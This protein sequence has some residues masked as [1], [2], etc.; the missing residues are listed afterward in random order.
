[1]C[2]RF[3]IDDSGD[4]AEIRKIFEELKK[5]YGSTVEFQNVKAGEIYPTDTVPVIIPAEEMRIDA[6]PM[7]WGIIN[8]R[9][10]SLVINARSEGVYGKAMFKESIINKRCIIPSTG[11]Y[12]WAKLDQYNKKEKYLIKP[13]RTP[14]LYLAGIY[15]KFRD[16]SVPNK[17]HVRFAVMTREAMGYVRSLHT[18]MPVTVER[19]DILKWLNGGPDNINEIFN[20]QMPEY[21]FTNLGSVG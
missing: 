2:G 11:F 12:E 9:D 15:T 5:H 13:A 18:R 20:G 14:M 21:A 7:Q 16:P 17:E 1:M 19:K 6:V 4:V 8:R 3:V 10:N